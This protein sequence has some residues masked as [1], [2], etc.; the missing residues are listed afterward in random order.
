MSFKEIGEGRR[1]EENSWRWRAEREN[2]RA[3]SKEA[4]PVV[5]RDGLL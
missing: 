3:I 2:I 1:R 5:K 4:V